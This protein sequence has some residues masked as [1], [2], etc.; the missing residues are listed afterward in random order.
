[1][2]SH[3]TFLTPPPDHSK[4]VLA[5]AVGL[6]LALVIHFSLSY[7]L[8]TPGDNIHSLPFGGY[9]KDGTKTV[10]YNSPGRGPKVS[11]PAPILL[12]FALIF[13]LHVLRK[14]DTSHRPHHSG[15]PH[16]S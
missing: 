2:S 16:C 4:S 14:R 9:Y 7:K 12:V 10:H 6:G 1:M 3:Q 15:C 8:P 5:V 11:G 13:A